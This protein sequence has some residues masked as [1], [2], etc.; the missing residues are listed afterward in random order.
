[1]ESSFET[2]SQDWS[3]LAE[4]GQH[5]VFRYLPSGGRSCFIGKVLRVR[6]HLDRHYDF[7]GA[8]SLARSSQFLSDYDGHV[9]GVLYA[10]SSDVLHQPA[11]YKLGKEMVLK[12]VELVELERRPKYRGK[13]LWNSVMQLED[14][15]W[16]IWGEI[17]P[18]MF[19]VHHTS[20]I[21]GSQD[22]NDDE[23]RRIVDGKVLLTLEL[24]I[25]GGFPSTS[26][27]LTT[28]ASKVKR[29]YGRYHLKQLAE[30]GARFN[31]MP[32]GVHDPR[33]LFSRDAARIRSSLG[34]LSQLPKTIL[35]A[36]INGE[37]YF[38]T[39]GGSGGS[40]SWWTSV[41]D[42]F[43]ANHVESAAN[44]GAI[45]ME[46]M[47]A[48][49][50]QSA[51]LKDLWVAQKLDLVDVEGAARI[52]DRLVTFAGD[53]RKAESK[54][55][56]SVTQIG[57]L[58]EDL[59]QRIYTSDDVDT[60]DSLSLGNDFPPFLRD[61]AE[62][63]PSPAALDSYVM[64]LS[65]YECC[66]LLN[67]WLISLAAKD[68]ALMTSFEVDHSSVHSSKCRFQDAATQ[69][70]AATPT[71][72]TSS[73]VS[74]IELTCPPSCEHCSSDNPSV[75]VLHYVSALIDV[76]YKEPSKCWSKVEEERRM[77]E[78]VSS[79]LSEE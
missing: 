69:M 62:L 5:V 64:N 77:C 65:S 63:Q 58:L 43:L 71:S 48:L 3:Y 46:A 40:S 66:V 11:Y 32:R 57:P 59:R 15:A 4:G 28:R 68:A 29:R 61:L 79:L 16:E 6:K 10:L 9:N 25:K 67:M 30:S 36:F 70:P 50:L 38:K 20:D 47:V 44:G 31:E 14:E 7:K 39:E 19:Q 21:G 53:Q 8:H 54:L 12:L 60:S 49:L 2:S 35:S 55:R 23:K 22:S 76:G 26:P 37:E 27:F 51:I 13:P 56:E 42:T 74:L 75:L 24:K 73:G 33:D 52:F 41:S 1:M 72:R 78:A 34:D 45:V 18:N 17:L